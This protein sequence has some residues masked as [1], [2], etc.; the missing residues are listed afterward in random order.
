[1]RYLTT[2]TDGDT[3]F[4]IY[5]IIRI[6]RIKWWS[7]M[8]KVQIK[9]TLGDVVLYDD[10]QDNVEYQS[11]IRHGTSINLDYK[12]NDRNSTNSSD[13]LYNER[14]LNF[15]DK[16]KDQSLVVF[17]SVIDNKIKDYVI[18]LD[19]NT[20]NFEV[21]PIAISDGGPCYVGYPETYKSLDLA[22]KDIQSEMHHVPQQFLKQKEV[23]LDSLN[24]MEFAKD[25]EELSQTKMKRGMSIGEFKEELG[26]QADEADLVS[27][28]IYNINKYPAD[29][30]DYQYSIDD[31]FRSG[32]FKDSTFT[33]FVNSHDSILQLQTQRDLG[34][35]TSLNDYLIAKSELGDIEV[36]KLS[37][38]PG[39]P[40]ISQYPEKF[41]NFN[42]MFEMLSA[43]TRDI[44][45]Q[46]KQNE[47]DL[48]P[49]FDVAEFS[50]SVTEL[51]DYVNE[52][53]YVM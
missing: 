18:G 27:N 50:E 42:D 25:I 22:L 40:A 1:M 37:Y 33:S 38:T 53:S 14:Y 34:N 20:D 43:E 39:A 11:Y 30:I 2:E 15:L 41:K 29:Y 6:K 44:P 3:F 28:D 13:V 36:M 47:I 9:E 7:I 12:Y 24:V 26:V 52:S 8:K 31:N 17:P 32:I 16:Y 46:F 4:K 10:L 5:D 19:K 35:D 23:S 48:S 45:L 51:N 21:M 49:N